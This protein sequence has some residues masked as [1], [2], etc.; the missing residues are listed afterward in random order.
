MANLTLQVTIPA[1]GVV[2]L[3]TAL[4]VLSS[5]QAPMTVSGTMYVEFLQFQNNSA[6]AIRYG[7]DRNVSVTTPAAANGGT[8]GRG[9]LLAPGSPGGAGAVSTPV[10]Y[11]TMIQDWYIAG[12][13]GDV[14]DILAV[15]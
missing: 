11:A 1:A 3:D 13:P 8:A 5:G 9:I 7:C 6:H 12:T 2:R 14:I 15:Q 4:P 10:T